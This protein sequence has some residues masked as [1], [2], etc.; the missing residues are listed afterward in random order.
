M[1]VKLSRAQLYRATSPLLDVTVKSCPAVLRPFA[2]TWHMVMG[3]KRGTISCAEYATL[4]FA[5]LSSIPGSQLHRWP[6]CR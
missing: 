4:Y 6:G 5:Q 1:R 3:V 2:P